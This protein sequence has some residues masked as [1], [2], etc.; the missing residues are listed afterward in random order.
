M[1]SRLR[2]G[3]RPAT[4][5]VVAIDGTNASG[6]I[7]ITG[8]SF[9]TASNDLYNGLQTIRWNR[10]RF[11]RITG[12]TPGAIQF[13]VQGITGG[14]S[15][16]GVVVNNAP[17]ATVVID[18]TTAQPKWYA[19]GGMTVGFKTVDLYEEFQ[20]RMSNLNSG[21]DGK[22][23]ACYVMAVALPS[24]SG[25]TIAKVTGTNGIVAFGDSHMD[26][27]ANDPV[28]V[29][30]WCGQLRRVALAAGWCLGY[31]GASSSTLCGDGPT[32]AD[33]AQEI[34]DLWA[35]MGSTTKRFLMMRRPNDY[36]YYAP[37]NGPGTYTP[38]NYQTYLEAVFAALDASDPG[39]TGICTRIDQGSS[40]G[41]NAGGFTRDNYWTATTN[42]ATSSG[43]TNVTT[44]DK[45]AFSTVSLAS[46]Y[47]EAPN[48][49][50]HLVQTGHDK[51]FAVVRTWYG[52]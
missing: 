25:G 27:D 48:G 15:T 36:A 17:F 37:A 13:L 43:R 32:A 10:S 34:H 30:G 45:T 41:A 46:D 21:I 9:V 2:L 19:V 5:T 28:S 38:T 26:G 52:L 39:W 11:V 29:N 42:A 14:S 23:S 6:A 35:A 20:D 12:Y 44:F 33:T 51:V 7:Q 47:F 40:W 31:A 18:K 49:Q 8:R 4:D 22:A 16:I 24:G 1:A 3:P 50:V